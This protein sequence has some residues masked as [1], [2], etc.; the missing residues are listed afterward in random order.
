MSSVESLSY[1]SGFNNQFSSEALPGALPLGRNSPQRAPYGLYAEQF[2]GTAF[3]V[4]RSEARRTWL[5]RIKP[6]ASHPRFERLARQIPGREPGPVNPNRL[7]WN[8]HDLPSEPTDFLD[9][10][11]SLAATADPEQAS[12]VSVHLYRANRSMDRVF[13]DADGEL[14]IVPQ[15]GR[16]RLATELGLL[17]IEPQE[18]AVIPRGLKFR[19]ELLDASA[20]G[21]ICENHGAA[22]RIPD[23]GPIGSNGLANPR[24]F[25]APV[26]RY[27]DI[28]APVQLV[29]KFLGELWA[30]ELDHSPLDV[31]AWHGNNV[32]YKYDLRLFNTLGTVSYDHPDPSIFTVLTSPSDTHGMANVDFVIFPPR[33]MVAESTFRPPW[34]HRNLM[35]EFMGL[36]LGAYDAKADGFAPGGASLH[37]CMS[38]H[39]PDNASTAQAIA[40]ELAPHKIDNTMAFMFETGRVLR[41]TRYALDCPQLQRDYDACW[42]GMAKTFQRN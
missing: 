6:S 27:E 3:T 13:F 32:P 7:R 1:L 22:L 12:G 10:L 37:N 24:D 31:V 5:Y 11:L 18:I 23:L 28:D 26:A 14:L 20:S 38:A 9:G 35:N 42:S 2:S 8:P 33:W 29:Q 25:L 16:L 21:Y 41:P 40:A 30:C 34:F 4:P 19:V 39:G 17:D 15:Q 36:I